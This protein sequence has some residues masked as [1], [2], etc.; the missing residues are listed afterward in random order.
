MPAKVRA[1]HLRRDTINIDVLDDMFPNSYCVNEVLA[2]R[3]EREDNVR[4][5]TVT[6][7]RIRL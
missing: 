2:E 5:E 1:D 4:S 7:I 6:K 3:K